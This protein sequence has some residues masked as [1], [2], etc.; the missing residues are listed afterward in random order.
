[1][2]RLDISFHDRGVEGRIKQALLNLSSIIYHRIYIQQRLRLFHFADDIRHQ[3]GAYGHG[4]TEAQM[5]LVFLC[6][7][8]FFH[9]IMLVEKLLGK[10]Q[11]FLAVLGNVELMAETVK[12]ARKQPG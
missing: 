9:G 7:H 8:G 3:A 4:R 5:Y 6:K 12:P 2:G 10:Y 1:M 11:K